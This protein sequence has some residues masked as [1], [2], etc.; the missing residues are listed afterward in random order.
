MSAIVLVGGKV[1][2]SGGAVFATGASGGGGA[3]LVFNYTTFTGSTPITSVVTGGS[4]NNTANGFAYAQIGADAHQSGGFDNTAQVNIQAFTTTATFVMPQWNNVVVTAGSPNITLPSTNNGLAVGTEVCLTGNF[5]TVTGF[6]EYEFQGY[7]VSSSSTVGGT[8]TIQLGVTPGGTGTATVSITGIYQMGFGIQNSTATTQ[9]AGAAT[10]TGAGCLADANIGGI[11]G[12]VGTSMASHTQSGIGNSVYVAWCMAQNSFHSFGYSHQQSPNAMT[13]A[14]NGGA[15]TSTE[16]LFDLNPYGLDLRSGNVFSVNCVYD[17]SFLDVTLTDT[18]LNQ[19][20]RMIFPL[21]NL[22]E[23]VGGNVAWVGFRAGSL[24]TNNSYVKTWSYYTG[25]NARLAAPTF[26]VVPGQYASTQTLTLTAPAGA[27]IYYTTNGLTPSANSTL[28][29]APISITSTQNIQAISVQTGY[30]PSY[31]SGGV[32]QIISGA[33]PKINFPAGFASAVSS[34]QLIT[35]G[36][37]VVSG[38]NLQLTLAPGAQDAQTGS[39]FYSTPQTIST[40]STSFTFS[41]PSAG[42]FIQ[43]SAAADQAGFTFCIQNYYQ[44]PTA[45]NT[46]YNPGWITG[47]PSALQ[48]TCSGSGTGNLG[49]VTYNNPGGVDGSGN[50]VPAVYPGFG[51][52]VCV[53]F[54]FT[55]STNGGVGLYVGNVIPIGSQTALPSTVSLVGNNPL[56]AAFTYDG[57]TL[58]LTLTDTVTLATFTNNWTVN[59]P[60]AVGASTAYVGFTSGQELSVATQNISAWTQ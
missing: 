26:S 1:L 13:V 14:I 57:T 3:T 11:G 16:P 46:P 28:Y 22:T 15:Y 58:A 4:G 38:S 51:N 25:Y 8:T 60:S 9:P 50:P 5:G 44:S 33:T 31:A 42:R 43:G 52:S 41:I 59:I 49:Y 39:A 47:G 12:E 53:A 40:F 35:N 56:T 17:G 32:I 24:Y 34:G 23:I 21:A 20:A 18:V 55:S 45:F 19:S 54:D 6:N 27:S 48:F 7:T 10:P 37:A 36:C 30:T 2:G 29:T